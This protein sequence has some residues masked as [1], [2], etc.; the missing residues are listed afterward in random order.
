MEHDFTK[1]E[2]E[3]F[4]KIVEWNPSDHQVLLINR[5]IR[6]RYRNGERLSLNECQSIVSAIC[7]GALFVAVEG[8]DNSDLNTILAMATKPKS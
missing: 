3:L 1:A 8:V 6:R 7:K 5:E 2:L 4:F